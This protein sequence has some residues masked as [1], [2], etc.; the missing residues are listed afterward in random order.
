[1]SKKQKIIVL[2]NLFTVAVQI[3]ASTICIINRGWYAF[4]YYTMDS[5]IFAAITSIMLIFS[6]L[7]NGKSSELIQKF[8][9]YS[10]C[11]VTLTFIVVVT[12]LVPIAGWH[13]LPNRLF[14]GTDLWLHTVGPLINVFSF[15]V[16]ETE[17]DLNKKQPLFAIIPTFIYA[18]IAI[19][20]N[21]ARVIDGPYVF[22]RIYDQGL[23]MTLVWLIVISVLVLGIAYSL[24]LGNKKISTK[25]KNK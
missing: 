7:K 23:L 1:M 6:L 21:L 11:C 22:L 12:I 25:S 5:N 4:Q 24:K 13:T 3:Y 18:V 19:I 16:L 17:F 15:L 20:L 8:R 10:T 9:Y 14:M 2:L